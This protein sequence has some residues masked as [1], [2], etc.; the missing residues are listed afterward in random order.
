M[1]DFFGR[2]VKKLDE[3][4]GS[5]SKSKDFIS[6]FISEKYPFAD[7]LE[8]ILGIYDDKGDKEEALAKSFKKLKKKGKAEFGCGLV[9][10]IE[11]QKDALGEELEEMQEELDKLKDEGTDKDEIKQIKEDMKAN[12]QKIK[13]LK[14]EARGAEKT[15]EKNEE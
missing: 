15:V 11:D 3:A 12:K 1:K 13:V 4:Q 9:D 14:K 5:K 8:F 10:D 6:D 2:F 7:F